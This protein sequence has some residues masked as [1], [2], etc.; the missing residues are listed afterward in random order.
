MST[1]MHNGAFKPIFQLARKHRDNATHSETILWGYLRTKP[2]GIKFRRQHPYSVFILDFYCHSLKL[3]IEVDGSI[4]N[5]PAVKLY[6]ERRQSELEKNGLTVIRFTNEQ[7]NNHLEQVQK[8]IE[9][10]I[11]KRKDEN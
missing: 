5:D 11:I 8:V 7:V 4:H 6:D 3:V 10:I 2:L 9:N 1:P